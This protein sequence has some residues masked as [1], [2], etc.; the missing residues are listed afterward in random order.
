MTKEQAFDL[1]DRTF[2]D[3]QFYYRMNHVRYVD[4]EF[5]LYGT[6]MYYGS[7]NCFVEHNIEFSEHDLE[8]VDVKIY[9]EILNKIIK[10]KNLFKCAYDYDIIKE[11]YKLEKNDSNISKEAIIRQANLNIILDNDKYLY[12]VKSE[13][14]DTFG[15]SKE[16]DICLHNLILVR[17]HINK[18]Q[19]ILD[20]NISYV[21][22]Y[23]DTYKLGFNVVPIQGY[24]TLT[25]MY[26]PFRENSYIYGLSENNYIFYPLGDHIAPQLNNHSWEHNLIFNRYQQIDE[27]IFNDIFQFL[28]KF[29]F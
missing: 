22:F 27:Y 13:Y 1:I 24:S 18:L 5:I 2:K 23:S 20:N 15:N 14:N 17:T 11:L 9:D 26:T 12:F 8:E 7:D 3:N 29:K 10:V 19:I 21:K 6:K 28:N 4:G 25:D 16:K